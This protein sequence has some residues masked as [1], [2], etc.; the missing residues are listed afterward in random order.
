ML[1][2]DLQFCLMFII[3]GFVL[4]LLLGSADQQGL[5]LAK[6]S[7]FNHQSME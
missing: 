4:L 6:K 5:V 2:V 3:L 7:H 1:A